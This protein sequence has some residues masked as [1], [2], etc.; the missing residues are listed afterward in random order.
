MISGREEITARM[1]PGL[2]CPWS[3]AIRVMDSGKAYPCFPQHSSYSESGGEAHCVEAR[4]AEL[5]GSRRPLLSSSLTRVANSSY[6]RNQIN[7]ACACD[8]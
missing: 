5:S 6:L 1:R 2:S 3:I 8:S 4:E 7:N